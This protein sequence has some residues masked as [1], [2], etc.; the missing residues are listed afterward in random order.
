MTVHAKSSAGKFRNVLVIVSK[1]AALRLR[2]ASVVLMN[3]LCVVVVVDV[4]CG[5]RNKLVCDVSPVRDSNDPKET[6]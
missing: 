1:K 6:K 5:E 3:E 2:Y 4:S